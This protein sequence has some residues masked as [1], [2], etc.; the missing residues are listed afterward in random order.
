MKL[1]ICSFAAALLTMLVCTTHAQLPFEFGTWQAF[2]KLMDYKEFPELRGRMVSFNWKDIEPSNNR[3]DWSSFDSNLTA[4]TADGKPV[5]FMV[6]TKEAAPDWIYQNGV[7]KVTETDNNGKTV[8]YSPYYA[9]DDYKFF[10]KRMITTVRQHVEKMDASVRKY[11]ISVEGCLGSTGDYISYKGN[12]PSQYYLSPTDFG[13]LYSEFTIK[14]YEEYKNTNPK[15]N[16]ISNPH[17]NGQEQTTWLLET[18]PGTWIKTGSIGKGYQLNDEKTKSLWLYNVLNT[19][20]SSG[21][22][23][24][25]RSEFSGQVSQTPWWRS[26]EPKNTFAVFCS[27]ISWGVDFSNQP[28]AQIKNSNNDTAYRFFNKYAGAKDPSQSLYA[29]SALKDVLDAADEAR[30]PASSFGTVSR[31]NQTRY[32]NIQKAYAAYGALLQDPKTAT[33]E[34]MDNLGA[35]G[36]NDVGWDLLPGN[37]ERFLEQIN[38]NETSVG[39]WNI[40]SADPNTIYGRFG[41]GFD[42]SKNKTALYF[43][44]DDRFLNG[45]PLNAGYPITIEVTY[46]DKGTGS[47][48]LV[49]DGKRNANATSTTVKLSNTN[50]WK[51]ATFKLSDAYFGNR[52]LNKSDF[53]LR[54]AGKGNVIFSIV[55]LARPTTKSAKFQAGGDQAD[56]VAVAE[57]RPAKTELSIM[58]NPVQFQFNLSLKDNREMKSVT[59]FDLSGKPVFERVVNA[60]RITISKSEI[61]NHSGTFVIRVTTGGE[62]YSSKI[63]VL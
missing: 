56:A 10:F 20:Q 30:F 40:A 26:S 15:I 11:I 16:L 23:V 24:R 50:K 8:G 32:L 22:F 58:P 3:W 31:T 9:D 4:S 21:D 13:N 6:Y 5:T 41:R 14:F 46:L 55:E 53:S 37:Y 57:N 43:N 45:A 12:V 1:S 17:N 36:I 51:K 49:Y 62:T 33:L 2:A 18:C 29:M 42:I 60:P 34:E 25:A 52:G 47:F 48:Q 54:N 63:I 44:V 28:P 19:K 27:E 38:P 61:G 7:P 35:K 39:Y 59:I